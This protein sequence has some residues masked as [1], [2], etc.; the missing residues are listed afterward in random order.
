[1]Q[2]CSKCKDVKMNIHKENGKFSIFPQIPFV[3]KIHHSSINPMRQWGGGGGGTKCPDQFLFVSQLEAKSQV[4]EIFKS[5]NLIDFLRFI[6]NFFLMWSRFICLN[7]YTNFL[8]KKSIFAVVEV[9]QIMRDT[10]K[11]ILTRLS[12]FNVKTKLL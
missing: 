4:Y 6:P 5:Q 1:M 2:C 11:I 8:V 7:R 9:K 12:C 3:S 10:V